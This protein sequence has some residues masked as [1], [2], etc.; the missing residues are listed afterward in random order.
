[1]RAPFFCAPVPRPSN[2]SSPPSVT[3][4]AFVVTGTP[5][6]FASSGP[7]A[8][9][10]SQPGR[11]R[12]ALTVPA[13][14]RAW[15]KQEGFPLDESAS[16]PDGEVKLSVASPEQNS[17]L[18]RNPDAPPIASRIALKAH[19]EPHVPQVVWY[20][21]GEPFATTDPDLPV[22]WPMSPG[23]HRFQVRLPLRDGAS[24]PVRVVV[25]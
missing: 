18:W 22:F 11:F 15:A 5:K 10:P 8:N 3:P 23:T 4:T 24:R 7:R 20:V 9:D 21:D 16:A 25:E 17:R 13:A 19:V 12:A 2:C 14:H 6:A 1:M